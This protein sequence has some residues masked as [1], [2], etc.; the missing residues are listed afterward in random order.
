MKIRE[1]KAQDLESIKEI[2]KELHP[3]W[4]DK[5]ALRNIPI[6]VQLQKC[7]VVEEKDKVIGFVTM[8]SKDGEAELG[9]IGVSPKW[10]NKGVG[11]NLVG[12]VEKE[13]RRLGIKVLRVKT[14]GETK[15]KY[16]PYV[17]TVAFYKSSGFGVEEKEEEKEE[18]GYKYR[19][20]T[21]RKTLSKQCRN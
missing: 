15:P 8:Y 9:W 11:K 1:F 20:Y 2:I 6:D 19:M 5:K 18:K 21:F 16:K 10:R 12:K 7:F 4:F 17:Q 14:V 13:A 3:K